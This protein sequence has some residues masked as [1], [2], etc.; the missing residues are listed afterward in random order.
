MKNKRKL[1]IISNESRADDLHSHE[2]QKLNLR[3]AM[4]AEELKFP[5]LIVAIVKD[6]RQEL[7]VML[8]NLPSVRLDVEQ[9]PTGFVVEYYRLILNVVKIVY[10]VKKNQEAACVA[11]HD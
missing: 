7:L 6:G 5:Y 11:H 1:S 2:L 4:M 3:H 10:S 9:Q 8:I